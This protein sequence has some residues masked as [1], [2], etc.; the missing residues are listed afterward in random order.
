MC[1]RFDQS[2]IQIDKGGGRRTAG[3]LV[4]ISTSTLFS[5]EWVGLNGARSASPFRPGIGRTRGRRIVSGFTVGVFVSISLTI[6]RGVYQ[7]TKSGAGPQNAPPNGG[8]G[9]PSKSESEDT[10][11]WVSCA[12][13][14]VEEG[15]C[16]RGRERGKARASM[17]L[18][19]ELNSKEIEEMDLHHARQ[20]KPRISREPGV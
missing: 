11:G 15:M 5:S 8:N 1:T 16:R 17:S 9:S 10:F 3:S 19:R 6:N 4:N 7:T 13:N 2:L 12:T 20:K 14:K 18:R